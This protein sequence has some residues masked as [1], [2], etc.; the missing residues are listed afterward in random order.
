MNTLFTVKVRYTK[1][2]DN[3][4]FKR[5]TEPYILAAHTFSDAEARIYEELGSIIRGEFN[6]VSI[7][8]TE[9]QDIFIYEGFDVFYKAVVSFDSYDDDGEVKKKQKSSFLV[10]ASSVKDANEKMKESLSGWLADYTIDAVAV[11]PVA[12]FFPFKEILD[13]EISRTMAEPQ[14]YESTEELVDELP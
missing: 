5:V 2:L 13:K 10:T 1:Q 8:R 9:L 11:T 12:D 3:G 6:V 14:D 7:T 4:A